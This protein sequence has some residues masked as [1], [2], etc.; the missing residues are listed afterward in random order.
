MRIQPRD[1]RRGSAAIELVLILPLTLVV[2][3]I[4]FWMARVFSAK[5]GS[6]IGSGREVH[7]RAVQVEYSGNDSQTQVVSGLSQSDL[8]TF[9]SRWPSRK[10]LRKGL[11]DGRS[12]V[13]SGK[14]V[15]VNQEGIGSVESHDWMLSDTWQQAFDFPSGMGEQPMMSLPRTINSIVPRGVHQINP[16]EFRR[17]LNF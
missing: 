10:S 15:L 2:I 7:T 8:E 3:L 13:D 1:I 14:G 16:N 12:S 17:L 4:F 9:L 6:W 5:Q 11:V